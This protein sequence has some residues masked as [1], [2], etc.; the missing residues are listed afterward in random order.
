MAIQKCAKIS[1][2]ALNTARPPMRAHES[3][4]LLRREH[5]HLRPHRRVSHAAEFVT[6][7]AALTHAMERHHE[8]GYIARHDHRIDVGADDLESMYDIAARRAERNRD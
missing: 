2:R 7:H 6:G 1:R 3:R 8:S 5:A 4:E